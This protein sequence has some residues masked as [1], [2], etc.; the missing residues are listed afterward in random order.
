[1]NSNFIISLDFELIWGMHEGDI[2]NSNYNK[3]IKGG[4]NAIPRLLEL[5]EK[6]KIHA[7][8][9]VVG[10]MFAEN[11]DEASK[12]FPQDNMKPSYKN[13]NL[14]PYP[15]IKSIDDPEIDPTLY[16]APDI[17]EK[18]A[19]TDGQEIASHSFSHFYCREDGQTTEQFEADML[20]AKAIAS[21]K[22]YNLRTVVLPRNQCVDEYIDVLAR[23]GFAAY[24]D[25]YDD[26]F[27]K[28]IKFQPLLRIIRLI[29]TYFP[30]TGHGG[31]TPDNDRGIVRLVGSRMLRP[32][33]K[34]LAFLEKM[35]IKRIKKQ[36]LHAAQNGLTF[37]LWWHP[38]N[39]GV[40]TQ[41]HL[42]MIED[43]LCYYDFLKKEYGMQSKTISESAEEHNTTPTPCI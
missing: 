43:I 22:G 19:K 13:M 37:H 32:Y 40:K 27:H 6:H 23:L 5:F 33:F 14:S 15:L 17:I 20:A 10:L 4:R 2:V 16:F 12:Y 24:R 39:I 29:D 25:D 26:W 30:I 35:K 9:A 34:P 21:D 31:Y 7:T 41:Y 38:H 3:N 1:M 42:D 11:A 36:M 28:N 8:W 18:I